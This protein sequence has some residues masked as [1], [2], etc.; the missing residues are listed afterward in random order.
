MKKRNR[1]WNRR[2]LKPVPERMIRF[3]G[4]IAILIVVI[5]ELIADWAIS[6]NKTQFSNSIDKFN[7]QWEKLPELRLS[8]MSIKELR[9]LALVL[10]IYGYASDNRETLTKRLSK[11]LNQASKKKH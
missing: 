9:R 8:M 10:N 7:T 4:I 6:L 3:Y 1:N 11:K 2:S 5:P